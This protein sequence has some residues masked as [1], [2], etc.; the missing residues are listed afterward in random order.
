MNATLDE[1]IHRCRPAFQQTRTWE[2]ARSLVYSSIACLGRHTVSGLLCATGGQFDDW[3]A[4]YRLFERE[5]FDPELLFAPVRRAVIDC[6]PETMP[7]VAAIDDTLIRKKGKKVAGAAW[8]RDPLGAPFGNPFTW[9]QRFLQTALLLPE[10]GWSGT[11]RAI[12]VDL[13]HAPTPKRPRRGATEEDWNAYRAAQR[14][15]CLGELSLQRIYRLRN[16]VDTDGPGGHR[17]RLIVVGDGGYTNRS[18]CRNIPH[19]TVFIG[20]IRRDAQ[21]HEIPQQQPGVGRRRLYGDRLPTPEALRQDE[22]V[23]WTEVPVFAAGKMQ[24]FQVKT[25]DPVRWKPAGG[26]N[27]VVVV[28]RPLAYRPRKNAHLLYRNPAYLVCTD[29]GLPIK[30]ILQAYVWRWDIEVAFHDEKT[31]LGMGEAQVR[32]PTAVPLVPALVAAS[33]GLLHVAAVKVGGGACELPLPKWRRDTPPRA[34]TAMLVNQIRA[35]L[36][37]HALGIHSDGFADKLITTRSPQNSL[38]TLA[39][40]TLYANN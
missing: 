22:S 34:T 11:A 7:I 14:S 23:P 6:L 1:L 12:P 32:T 20:R 31:I 4:A 9:G 30:M 35:E 8:R 27:L 17:R 21:L 40:A 26:R 3:S 16:L 29:P 24:T 15:M 36:W 13:V 28:I 39:H 33:Y 25:L 18:V 37:G 19:D 38:P 2:R 10:N 5:R